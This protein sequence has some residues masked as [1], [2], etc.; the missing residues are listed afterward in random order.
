MDEINGT[1]ALRLAKEI[2][3]IPGMT[4]TIAFYSYSRAKSE[5][6]AKLTVK[7]GCTVRK[8]LP[9]DRFSIDSENFFLFTDKH[10]KP[11]ACYKILIRYMGFPQDNFKLRKT[12][13]I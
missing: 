13:M 5:A 7:E 2:S 9:E 3:Q 1:E 10:G 4:F 12:K 8:Q 6:S 11:K